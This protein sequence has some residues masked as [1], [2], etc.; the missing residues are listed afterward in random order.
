[1]EYQTRYSI[2]E[3]IY[4]YIYMEQTAQRKERIR[5]V[6]ELKYGPPI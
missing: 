4:I 3:E 5:V 2:I 1:M 6:S